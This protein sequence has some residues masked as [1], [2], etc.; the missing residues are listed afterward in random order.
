MIEIFGYTVN[1]RYLDI[2]FLDISLSRCNFES[3]DFLPSLSILDTF[4]YLDFF[5][6]IFSVFCL[7]N[8]LVFTR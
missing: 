7:N 5:I 3:P 1:Y 6:S 4:V 8:L 2:A